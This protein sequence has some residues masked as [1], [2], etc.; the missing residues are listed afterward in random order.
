MRGGEDWSRLAETLLGVRGPG[1]GDGD[2]D[3]GTPV[4]GALQLDGRRLSKKK[5]VTKRST[6]SDARH[7]LLA[8]GA[9]VELSAAGKAQPKDVIHLRQVEAI[10]SNGVNQ[11]LAANGGTAWQASCHM[12]GRGADKLIDGEF[13]SSNHT[14]H[15]KDSTTR[16]TLKHPTDVHELVIHNARWSERWQSSERIAGSVV[17]LLGEN[18]SVIWSHT[19]SKAVDPGL[20]KPDGMAEAHVKLLPFSKRF[21]ASGLSA[22]DIGDGEPGGTGVDRLTD[23]ACCAVLPPLTGCFDDELNPLVSFD[24]AVAS[25]P[26]NLSAFA[27]QAKQWAR[28]DATVA[29]IAAVPGLTADGAMAIWTYT[30]DSPLYVHLNEQLRL[31]SRQGLRPFFPFLRLLLEALTTIREGGGDG[32]MRMVNRGVTRDLLAAHPDVYRVGESFVWWGFSSC[33]SNIGVLSNPLFL[34][35]GGARTI[36]QVLTRRGAVVAPFS[37][38]TSEAEVLLPAGTALRIT[39]ILPQDHSG[40]TIITCEDDPDAPQL[41]N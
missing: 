16:I 9:Y 19:F 39:G 15:G 28:R 20:F 8:S 18:R 36:F 11:A 40:L 29:A 12:D 25:Q 22:I 6:Q 17:R 5:A 31:E 24:A 10:D 34:G 30:A 3:C 41:I 2:G 38:I 7:A 21:T 1:G 32:Q 37:A 23:D 4:M 13:E 14:A 27:Y 26:D 33:T 35:N